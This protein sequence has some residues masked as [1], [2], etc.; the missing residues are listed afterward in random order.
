MVEIIVYFIL[1]ILI[2]TGIILS[3]IYRE[4]WVTIRILGYIEHPNGFFITICHGKQ[5]KL[6]S[7]YYFD[8]SFVKSITDHDITI[9]R[10]ALSA[11][12]LI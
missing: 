6:T 2:C 7:S 9:K 5:I 10:S 4:R 12:G 3:K 8:K 11:K 1:F